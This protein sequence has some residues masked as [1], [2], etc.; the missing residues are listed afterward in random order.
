[1]E[2]SFT[3]IAYYP[4]HLSF[5]ADS[6]YSTSSLP[7]PGSPLIILIRFPFVQR[8]IGDL[9]GCTEGIGERVERR[10]R[11][12]QGVRKRHHFRSCKHCPL[13]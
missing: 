13:E 12:E 3:Y 2:Y 11:V 8:Q 7:L 9:G 1:M 6:F 5:L 10:R 4:S